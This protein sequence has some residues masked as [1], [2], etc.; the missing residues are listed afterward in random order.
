MKMRFLI[1]AVLSAASVFSA[2]NLAFLPGCTKERSLSAVRE[3]GDLAMRER[4]FDDAA[5]D[6]AEYA[7][8]RP[9]NAGVHA[10]LGRALLES[11]RAPEAAEQ[12]R[13]AYAL[14]P[15]DDATLDAL[16][17]GL[18]AAG[19][20]DELYRLLRDTVESQ[21]RVSDYLRLGRF[22]E[23]MGDR[24]EAVTALLTGARLDAGK[25]AAPQLALAE[26]YEA[27]GDRAKA[28]ERL[29]MAYWIDP[30]AT[31]LG[32]KLR[33]FGE[34]PGPTAGLRPAEMP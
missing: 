19:Q 2:A 23:R 8:R 11:G 25:S 6:Y 13:L 26:F 30:N 20:H 29:R 27:A 32:T 5:V 33:S 15:T 3:S 9:G 21:G 24:D 34:V 31:G 1:P 12:L 18:L 17:D 7:D 4:R 10:N 14:K 22:A 28:V 16:A